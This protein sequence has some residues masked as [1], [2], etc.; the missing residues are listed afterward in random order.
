MH[1]V[2]GAFLINKDFGHIVYAIVAII[3]SGR[4]FYV[5]VIGPLWYGSSRLCSLLREG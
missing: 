5:V 2:V 3:N 4:S 1:N